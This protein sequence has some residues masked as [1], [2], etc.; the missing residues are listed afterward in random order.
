MLALDR[1]SLL[2]V[3]RRGSSAVTL[4]F[5]SPETSARHVSGGSTN[6]TRPFFSYRFKTLFQQAACFDSDTKHPGGAPLSR[7]S[8]TLR[9][10]NTFVSIDC[11]LFD[12]RQIEQIAYFQS[13]PHSSPRSFA[14]ER[15]STSSISIDCERFRENRGYLRRRNRKN[16]SRVTSCSH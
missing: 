5:E 2:A 10:T 16:L 7:S 3:I 14:K 11:A 8:V 4:S 15:K 13:L 9:E 12:A 6:S 1:S